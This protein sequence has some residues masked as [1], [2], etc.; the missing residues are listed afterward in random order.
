MFL[1][2]YGSG[3]RGRECRTLRIKDVCF[4]SSQIV[5]RNGKGDKDRV[6]VLPEAVK[7]PLRLQIEQALATHAHDLEQGFGEVYL[8][9]AL[10]R[11]YPG[12]S[13]ESCWQYIFPSRKVC[14]DPRSG[15]IRR[16]H[17]HKD[18]FADAMKKAR[19]STQIMKHAVPHTLRHSFA[20]HALEDGYDI[21]TLGQTNEWNPIPRRGYA[22]E[23]RSANSGRDH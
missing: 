22:N 20:T 21:R 8:P 17:V 4:E 1:L 16:H 5:V 14:R 13:R 15:A 9:F 12:A 7:Q 18:T 2:L 10:A 23:G 19:R 6:T 3:L 11:K